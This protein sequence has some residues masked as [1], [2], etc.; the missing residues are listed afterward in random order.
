MKLKVSIVLIKPRILMC[1]QILN[2]NRKLGRM[3]RKVG[4]YRRVVLLLSQNKIAGVSR[5]LSP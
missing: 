4:D 3:V 2:L 5:I 1:I